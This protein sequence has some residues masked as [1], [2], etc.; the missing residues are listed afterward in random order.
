MPTH[1]LSSRQ[2]FQRTKYC[3]NEATQ[4]MWRWF[5]LSHVVCK[6]LVS[7]YAR[8]VRANEVDQT[9]GQEAGPVLYY[10]RGVAAYMNTKNVVSERVHES[11]QVCQKHHLRT[12]GG[13]KTFARLS[14][15]KERGNV[16]RIYDCFV[17][18]DVFNELQ[19]FGR[20]ILRPAFISESLCFCAIF[21]R[22]HKRNTRRLLYKG[23]VFGTRS[24]CY[25]TAVRKATSQY[26]I[27]RSFLRVFP[28]LNGCALMEG[29]NP[30]VFV[31]QSIFRDPV[32]L[33]RYENPH[34]PY[35]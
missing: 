31:S 13:K 25:Q 24:T 22:C 1:Y 15:Q 2:I 19:S 34:Y 30:Q 5:G 12:I 23:I 16:A 7:V 4:P 28:L 11:W 35:C 21:D 9:L 6:V 3:F 14:W 10:Y 8:L 17:V 29:R 32:F 18:C 33:L 27:S 20:I 26:F